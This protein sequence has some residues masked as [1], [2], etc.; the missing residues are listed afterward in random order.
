MHYVTGPHD[1]CFRFAEDKKDF[2]QARMQC[3][4]EGGTLANTQSQEAYTFARH[5]IESNPVKA[6]IAYGIFGE[7][8]LFTP[9]A[10]GWYVGASK[11]GNWR[12]LNGK[13]TLMIRVRLFGC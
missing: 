10:N 2:N 3:E 5:H 8:T 7:V 4:S 13:L 1:L 6:N 12:W 11:H 9:W